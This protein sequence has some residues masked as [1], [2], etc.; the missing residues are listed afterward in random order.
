MPNLSNKHFLD[1]SWAQ[2]SCAAM[3]CGILD[4]IIVEIFHK[5]TRDSLRYP[6]CLPVN[7]IVRRTK[8]TCL[9]WQTHEFDLTNIVV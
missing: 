4:E 9:T 8:H 1:T 3:M 2:S 7:I 5:Y 6:A